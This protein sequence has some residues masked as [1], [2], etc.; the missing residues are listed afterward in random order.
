M[1]RHCEGGPSTVIGAR[2]CAQD[3]WKLLQREARKLTRLR[4]PY[5]A[6]VEGVVW[7]RDNHH[8]YMMSPFYAGGS[9]RQRIE[10]GKLSAPTARLLS[11]QV[12]AN[13]SRYMR[14]TGAVNVAVRAQILLAVEH[15][16]RCDEVHCDIKPDNVFL[17]GDEAGNEVRVRR[18]ARRFP[19]CTLQMLDGCAVAVDASSWATL[20]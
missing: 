15:I 18:A 10:R 8:V 4:H 5:V 16:H 6:A 13:A 9:L 1:Y 19:G 2:G 3:D 7:D 14:L 12:G 11:K 17:T 20:T